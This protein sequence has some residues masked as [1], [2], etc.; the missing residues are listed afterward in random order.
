MCFSNNDTDDFETRTVRF[1]KYRSQPI[2]P[3]MPFPPRFRSNCPSPP[4]SFFPH[5]TT[6]IRYSPRHSV[7][8]AHCSSPS[9]SPRTSYTTITRRH[10][11]TRLETIY[12][13]F[14]RRRRSW[15]CA[16]APAPRYIEYI[17]PRNRR[18]DVEYISI[19]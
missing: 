5:D 9:H 18:R 16:S 19:A 1:T 17:E 8:S 14:T 15:E 4:P 7:S 10:V 13:I 12:P 2:R 11:H 6:I 3:S